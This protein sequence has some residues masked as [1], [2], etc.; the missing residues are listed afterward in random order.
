MTASLS[1]LLTLLAPQQPADSIAAAGHDTIP[2]AAIE[3]FVRTQMAQHALPGLAIA[4]VDGDRII[5]A[6]GFGERD[7]FDDDSTD[8]VI[9][10]TPFRVASVSKLFTDIGVMQRVERGAFHLDSSVTRYATA[11]APSNPFGTAPTLRNLLQHRSGLVREPPVGHYF[12]P[13]SPT[14][15][16]TVASLNRTTLVYAPGTVTKYSNAAIALVGR[17]LELESGRP[18]AEVMER[19]VL[20]PSGMLDASFAPDSAHLARRARGL[21][22]TLDGRTMPAP[23]FPLGLGPASELSASMI[24][25]GHFLSMLFA[26]GKGPGAQVLREETLRAMWGEGAGAAQGLFGLGFA[27]GQLDGAR[28]IGHGGWHYGF[29]TELAALPDEKLGVAV[30]ATV[31]GAGAVT[32]RIANEALRLLRDARAGRPMALPES[33]RPIAPD[34]RRALE[35]TYRSGDRTVVLTDRLGDLWFEDLRGA[36]PFVLRAVEDSVFIADGRLNY[37]TRVVI[38]TGGAKPTLRYAGMEFE[39]AADA[40]PAPPPA[41][42]R[43]LIGEYGWDHDVLYILEREGRLFALIEWFG[44]Y[45]LEVVHPDTLQFPAHGMYA[46]ERLGVVRRA[47]DPSKVAALDLGGVIFH[48]R[49]V[50]PEDGATFHIEPQRPIEILRREALAATPPRQPSGLLA[51]DLVDV[52]TVDPRARIRL[53]VRYATTDNFMGVTMYDA[54]RARL[55]RPAAE[56]LGRVQQTLAADGLGLLVHDAYRPWYVTKMFWDAT[57][58][59]LRVF[60]ADPAVGSRHNRGAAVDLTLYELTTGHPV[61]MVSGYDEFSP[62]AYPFYPGGTSEQRWFRRRLRLAMQAEGFTVYDAEWWHFDHDTWRRY[63]VSNVR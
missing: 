62:R 32:T 4:L 57:P 18:F 53:D 29:A 48:R 8:R 21:M 31:D 3:R 38:R 43:A 17:L 23:T 6:K 10:S 20:R 47:D 14:L 55:Q 51:A 15:A 5:W 12:D 45:P 2:V 1:L 7:P 24:D 59:S 28:R 44:L 61:Q 49:A 42:W 63:G 30:S 50:G 25:L 39:R 41:E 26:G 52:A 35:G 33:S 56:A 27:L 46:G 34:R 36:F 11:F 9:A 54:P 16:R 40:R 22:W 37:G 13:T 60:V 19:D 58:D